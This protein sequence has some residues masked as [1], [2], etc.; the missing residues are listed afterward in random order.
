MLVPL[1]AVAF[2]FVGNPTRTALE[3]PW[4]VPE[5]GHAANAPAGVSTTASATTV[6]TT[7]IFTGGSATNGAD[8]TLG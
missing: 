6:E 5:F 2:V 7:R 1:V 8:E 4:P 3:K